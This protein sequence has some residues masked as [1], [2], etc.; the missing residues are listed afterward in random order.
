MGA[1]GKSANPSFSGVSCIHGINYSMSYGNL[2]RLVFYC[3]TNSAITALHM[4]LRTRCPYA[5]VLITVLRVSRSCEFFF[6]DGFDLHLLPSWGE[7]MRH[8]GAT[9]RNTQGVAHAP[10][11]F[12]LIHTH[13]LS[14][15]IPPSL[16][17]SLAPSLHPSL[18]PSLSLSLSLSLSPSHYMIA[19]S[20]EWTESA[21]VER[22]YKTVKT[23]FWPCLSGKSP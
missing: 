23:R 17:S 12:S 10:F 15:S 9:P 5:Y 3:K 6:P 4:P 14:P 18:H 8:R 16:P 1:E 7:A 20:N 13:N 11:C 2:E 21:I 19:D 22:T